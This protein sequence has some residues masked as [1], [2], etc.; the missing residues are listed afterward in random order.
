MTVTS[1]SP[2]Q[3]MARRLAICHPVGPAARQN[4]SPIFAF[5]RSMNE[6]SQ[7]PP[8]G[9][10]GPDRAPPAAMHPES[11]MGSHRRVWPPHTTTLRIAAGRRS[12]GFRQSARAIKLGAGPRGNAFQPYLSPPGVD[13][14]RA[15]HAPVAVVRPAPDIFEDHRRCL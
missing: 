10:A 5:A 13:A 3:T 11:P 4:E 9:D 12:T 8:A 14:P 2:N 6:A 1:L 15:K 7:R